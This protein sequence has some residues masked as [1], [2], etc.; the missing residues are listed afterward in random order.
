MTNITD[1]A[2]WSSVPLIDTAD[3]VLGGAGG[4]D[5]NPHQAL[6][7]RTAYLKAQIE[8]LQ[9]AAASA[10][11]PTGIPLPFAGSVLPNGFLFCNGAAVSRTTYANLFN[12]IGTT[13]GSGDG[14]TTF[15]VPNMQRRFPLGKSSDLLLGATGGEE[16]HTLTLDEAPTHSHST[17]TRTTTGDVLLNHDGSDEGDRGVYSTKNDLTGS[18]GGGAAHNNMPPYLVMNWIIKT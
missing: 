4:I 6:A 14:T 7:N 9:T 2:E 15:N 11:I 17:Y 13:Y 12:V 3:Y 5:N 16:T 18:A 10:L 8:A 1:T